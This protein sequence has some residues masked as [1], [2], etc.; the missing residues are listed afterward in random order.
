MNRWA[1][2][3]GLGLV[4]LLMGCGLRST[5]NAVGEPI[6][7]CAEYAE[8]FRGCMDRLGLEAAELGRGHMVT[9]GPSINVAPVGDAERATARARCVA[10]A[11]SLALACR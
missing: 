3:R 11:K 2:C 8:A 5:E 1:L 9:V 7:E 4:S 10:G 6:K